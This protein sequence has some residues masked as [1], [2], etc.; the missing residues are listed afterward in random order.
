MSETY[1]QNKKNGHI[2]QMNVQNYQGAE[3]IELD[4]SD[5]KPKILYGSNGSGK[6]STIKALY[7]ALGGKTFRP[8]KIDN[9]VGPYSTNKIKKA[10]VKIGIE[11]EPGILEFNGHSLEKF[12]VNFSITQKGNVSLSVTDDKE[13]SDPISAPREKIKNLLGLFLDP[14]E[15]VKTLENPHGDRELAEKLCKMVGFDI[16]PFGKREEELFQEKQEELRTLR[17]YEGEF[18]MMD[19]PQDDWAKKYVDPASI[20]EELQKYN[21]YN[22]KEETKKRN[23]NQ[24][25]TDYQQLIDAN[26][27]IAN[28]I[29]N[30]ESDIVGIKHRNDTK[31]KE[32]DLKRESFGKFKEENKPVEWTGTQNIEEKIAALTKELTLFRE[33]EKAEQEKLDQINA[34]KQEI[35]LENERV[36][37]ADK[38]AKEK[39]ELIEKKKTEKSEHDKLVQQKALSKEKVMDE[40]EPVEWTGEKD[41]KGILTPLQFLNDKMANVETDNKQVENRKKYYEKEESIR[42]VKESI[43]TIDEKRKQNQVVKSKAIANIK[44][45]F[46]HPGIT[47]DY[48]KP[49]N[50][51]DEEEAKKNDITVWVDMEDGR[52]KRTINDISEGEKLLICTHILIAGNTGSLNILVVR[53]GNK[54]DEDHQK[55]IFDT[56]MKFG[57][58]VILETIISTY[59]GAFHIKDGRIDSIR[60][61]GKD[62]VSKD[63]PE[64]N[65]EQKIV[66]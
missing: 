11:G 5:G 57:Y 6:S 20:S 55:I 21:D 27:I 51:E 19:V 49:F 36:I 25:N 48:K 41:P 2:F 23:I 7:E 53:S 15:L 17:A 30:S 61:D 4:M 10:L 56:A 59:K 16:T 50:I 42:L 60:K 32:L 29:V 35:D 34:K 3:V 28:E 8:E 14:V 26:N 40:N 39:Q 12:Y 63:T 18:S 47:I 37:A 62:I 1:V 43:K 13:G 33:H 54:L 44:E 9:P 52:G 22:T 31:K 24:F 65:K 58:S 38:E 46:P 45:K 64:E 66:W